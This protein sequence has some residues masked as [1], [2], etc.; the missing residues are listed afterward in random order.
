MA[1]KPIPEGFRSVAPYL[2]VEGA[3]RL[4]DFVKQAFGAE[5]MSVLP[6]PGGEVAHASVRIGDSVVMLGEAT[7]QA[8]AMPGAV[9]LYVED[10]QAT[11]QRALEAG[12]SSMLE[13]TDLFWGDRMGSVRDPVGNI[14]YIG[15]HIEDVPPEELPKRAAE[16]AA[17]RGGS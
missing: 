4:L 3:D 17:Q 5:E 2:T 13:P 15:T 7:E 16:W 9:N 8:P 11:Y 10:C 12:A 1:V 6:G 14:W